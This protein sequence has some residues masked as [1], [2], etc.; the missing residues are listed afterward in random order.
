MITLDKL[1]KIF[2]TTKVA[3]LDQYVDPINA[4]FSRFGFNTLQSQCC[5][6]AQIGHESA[7]LTATKENLNYSKDGLLKIF[8]K[9]FTPALAVQYARKPEAIANRVYANRM[10]N[11]DEK[12]GDGWKYRGRGLIQLTGK[13]NYQAFKK[14][15]GIYTDADLIQYMDSPLGAVMSGGWFFSINNLIPLADKGDMLTLTKR[16]NGGLN[17]LA[18]R[19][20]LYNAATRVVRLNQ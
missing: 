17:G 6:I 19:M 11:G 16:I 7:G 12:S 3:I 4:A 5:F 1:Q 18:H 14:F 10:G 8:P 13:N 2:P 20:T 9:Y 15:M